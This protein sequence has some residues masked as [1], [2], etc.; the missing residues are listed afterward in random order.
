M[1]LC[2]KISE[3]SVIGC[4]MHNP[5]HL[6]EVDKY[7]FDVRDFS[8]LFTRSI[9]S[10]IQNLYLDGARTIQVIDIDSYIQRYPDL[11][12]EFEKNQGVTYL[13]DCEDMGEDG[14]F[15]YYYSRLRKF[16]CLRSLDKDGFDISQF[17]PTNV[18]DKDYSDK[19]KQFDEMTVTEIFD[20]LKKKLF[21]L[22]EG[23][24]SKASSTSGYI[25]DGMRALKEQ[26]KQSPEIG[27]PLQGK[28]YN[29][30]VRGARKGKYYL[31]SAASG[32]GKTRLAVG[33]ACNLAYPIY[34]DWN[35]REWVDKHYS[36]K[37]YGCFEI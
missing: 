21:S 30:V 1:D 17:Y 6:S 25:A 29:T 16:S 31:R 14:N 19:M 13:Q 34:F 27:F 15:P 4:L 11:R 33:D 7:H 32:V 22:E 18:L 5:L 36:E 9:F 8:S 23:Y 37:E 24:V 20:G 35:T 10:S 12:V 3:M 2:D 26:L 28:Y